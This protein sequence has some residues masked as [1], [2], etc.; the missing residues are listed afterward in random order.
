[1]ILLIL[2]LLFSKGHRQNIDNISERSSDIL[3]IL[4][5]KY[6]SPINQ[7]TC[8][9]YP[10]CSAYGKKAMKKHGVFGF[11]MVADRLNRCGHDLHNYKN[12]IVNNQLR[13]YDP[14][15]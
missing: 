6:I 5:Q 13:Y 11:F 7:Q 9:M 12:I 15:N 2:G 14:I 8:Q 10:S 1:M 4:Y 3:I